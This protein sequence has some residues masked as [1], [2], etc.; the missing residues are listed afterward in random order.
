MQLTVQ[1]LRREFAGAPAARGSGLEARATEPAPDRA[2]GGDRSRALSSDRIASH[3]Y[4]AFENLYRGD[5]AEIRARM[6][7][8]VPLF[9]RA[10]DVLDIGCGR[11]EFLQL[12]KEQGIRASGID[13][14]HEMVEHCRA[15]GL[16]VSEADALAA[17]RTR[18][19]AS[20]GGLVAAQVVEHLEPD[21]LIALLDEAFRTLR[22]GSAIAL[23]TINVA[24]WSAF[25]SSYLRD[26]THV[27]PIHPETLKFLALAA[28]FVD[29]DIRW[30]AP[31]GEGDKLTPSPPT[32]RDIDLR[33]AGVEGRALLEL[34]DAF[35]RNVE[36]LNSQL[37][38]PLDYALI[39][40][41]R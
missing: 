14:N 35:D 38:G 41:K 12:L 2:A 5:P 13:L 26:L 24:S 37:Y 40:W 7:D 23:E 3:K 31:L 8:Y 29:A 20:L 1:A 27:R 10:E 21:Y 22:P 19:D 11:G 4:L 25:F 17:L 15:A 18:P 28:G 34:A 39:A 36:R 6:T 33:T 16:D 9:A 30:R 32:V